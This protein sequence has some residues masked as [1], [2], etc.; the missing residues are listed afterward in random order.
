VRGHVAHGGNTKV[1]RCWCPENLTLKCYVCHMLKEHNREPKWS[2]AVK[3][4]PFRTST[5]NCKRLEK[6]LAMGCPHLKAS[7]R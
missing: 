5:L 7:E 1:T 6:K 4:A 2:F 3:P